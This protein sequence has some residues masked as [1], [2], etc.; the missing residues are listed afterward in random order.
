MQISMFFF[1]FCGVNCCEI[2]ISENIMYV[3]TVRTQKMV[4]FQTDQMMLWMCI[5]HTLGWL[6][7]F[8]PFR[9]SSILDLFV[10]TS[11]HVPQHLS[12]SCISII[13]MSE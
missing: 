9:I 10:L 13:L 6:V 4:G 7:M 1:V 2:S 3:E 5:I 11:C 12:F 8:F